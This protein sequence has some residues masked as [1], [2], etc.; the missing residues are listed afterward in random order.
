MDDRRYS[1]LLGAILDLS[2]ATENGFSNMERNVDRRFNELEERWDR[3]FGALERQMES[4]FSEVRISL[5]DI[6]T[7]L[8]AVE[9]R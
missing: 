4:G 1:E 3:R 9:Q 2:A 8:S 6:T 5:A 7:R